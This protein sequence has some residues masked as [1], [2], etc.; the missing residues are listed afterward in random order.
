MK[1][2]EV[3]DGATYHYAGSTLGEVLKLHLAMESYESD[4]YD[5][6][7]IEMVSEERARKVRISDEDSG[8]T[9]S[10]W[11]WAQECTQAALI[12]CSEW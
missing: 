11:D 1:V 5:S 8:E 10:A 4:D 12:G 2:Y 7:S 3:E 9:K 6:L